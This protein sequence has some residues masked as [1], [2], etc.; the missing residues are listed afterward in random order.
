MLRETKLSQHRLQIGMRQERESHAP[1]RSSIANP[2]ITYQAGPAATEL[3][4]QEVRSQ[5]TPLRTRCGGRHQPMPPC[6]CDEHQVLL[7]LVHGCICSQQRVESRETRQP[8]LLG[9]VEVA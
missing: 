3:G 1:L 4:A 7:A 2:I 5:L 6:R 8:D 9:G